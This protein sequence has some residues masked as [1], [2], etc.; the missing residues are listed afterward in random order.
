MIFGEIGNL[1]AFAPIRILL[2][3]VN[4]IVRDATRQLAHESSE[5]EP[6]RIDATTEAVRFR[7]NGILVRY[8]ATHPES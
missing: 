8:S 3:L 1:C 6:S 5:A 7:T 2:P 4:W